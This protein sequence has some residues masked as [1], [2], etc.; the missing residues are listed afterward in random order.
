[1]TTPRGAQERPAPPVVRQTR[2]AS[3]GRGSLGGVLSNGMVLGRAAGEMFTLRMQRQKGDYFPETAS[4]TSGFC[5]ASGSKMD[6]VG[7][8]EE[9]AKATCPLCWEGSRGWSF[10]SEGSTGC[11]RQRASTPT[12]SERTPT[13]D[14]GAH[15]CS[16][17]P[18]ALQPDV[19]KSVLWNRTPK[20]I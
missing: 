11:S 7:S 15:P 20:C 1:M 3:R 14:W 17:Q 19:P 8:C 4:W 2:K 16:R 5:G 13:S 6:G 9:Q 18:P 12:T 10:Q